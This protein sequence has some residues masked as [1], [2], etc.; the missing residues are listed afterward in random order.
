[1]KLYI[2]CFFI[3]I[4]LLS[5]VLSV[6]SNEVQSQQYYEVATNDEFLSSPVN[7]TESQPSNM[8][9]GN[10]RFLL[11][12]HQVR[13]TCNKFPSMLR[14]ALGLIVAKRSVLMCLL[15]EL[16]VG[17]VGRSA[18]I[19]RYAAKGNVWTHLSIEGIVVAATTGAKMEGF[20]HLAYA[21]MHSNSFLCLNFCFACMSV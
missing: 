18:S 21:T 1:M 3:S 14:E 11:Q 19:M 8:L 12:K 9:H 16:T 13:L 10:D 2:H 15:T 4:L 17:G 20:V 7:K 6:E 5:H